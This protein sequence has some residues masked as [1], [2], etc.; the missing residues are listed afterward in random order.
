MDEEYDVV[1][2]GTGLKEC[3]LSGLLSVDGLKVLF[4]S[5]S[6]SFN[7]SFLL[8]IMSISDYCSV[9][10][11]KIAIGLLGFLILII[12]ISDLLSMI[13][14]FVIALSIIVDD[15]GFLS[16]LSLILSYFPTRLLKRKRCFGLD[17]NL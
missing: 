15:K 1:V 8:I 10:S 12:D 5:L 14:A 16:F 2:L 13:Q 7:S 6:L 4:F 9:S 17:I 11:I 3:I